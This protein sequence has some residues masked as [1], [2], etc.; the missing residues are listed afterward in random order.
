M[1][2][3]GR[4]GVLVDV[5]VG[6]PEPVD[7]HDHA[8]AFLEWL[9]GTELAGEWVGRSPLEKLYTGMFAVEM[10]T[11]AGRSSEAW[12]TAAHHL[13]E[14]PGVKTRLHDGRSRGGKSITVYWI[15]RRRRA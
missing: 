3:A 10:L 9:Q 6:A 12:R 2:A 13:R 11:S 15:R 8:E 7:A 14:L 5:P 4:G 1:G